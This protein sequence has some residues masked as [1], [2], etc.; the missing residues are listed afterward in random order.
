MGSTAPDATDARVRACRSLAISPLNGS[1]L[2]VSEDISH[3]LFYMMNTDIH[4]NATLL[5]EKDA[6][7]VI[8]YIRITFA[9][10]TD[11]IC[12]GEYTIEINP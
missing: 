7:A 9:N 11:L 8:N 4:P 10:N 6:L 5:F 1:T 12:P 3:S 2:A